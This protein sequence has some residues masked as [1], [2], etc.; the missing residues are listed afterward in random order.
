MQGSS[1]ASTRHQCASS[2][3]STGQIS[4]NPIS[5][6]R[7]DAQNAREP[8]ILC[9]I[10]ADSLTESRFIESRGGSLSPTGLASCSHE[11]DGSEFQ[12]NDRQTIVPRK[13][14]AVEGKGTGGRVR[15]A[16]VDRGFRALSGLS[17]RLA[18]LVSISRPFRERQL[19]S[20]GGDL[21]F[22][23]ACVTP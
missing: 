8:T 1:S 17:D 20:S 4:S 9:S 5:R 21:A 19:A 10:P 15:R 6:S 16:A 12:G 23:S 2:L 7:T 18:Q 13:E 22:S 11:D 3:P 14:A